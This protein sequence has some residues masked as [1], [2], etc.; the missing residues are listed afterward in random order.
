VLTTDQKGNIAEQAIVFQA[1]KLGIDVYRPVGE[2]GPYDMLRP[3][4]N[5]QR[6]GIN[7]AKDYEFRRY[8]EPTQGAI[9]QLGERRRGTPKVTGSNP[10]GSM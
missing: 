1:I 6:N 7:W 10:V 8:T 5:N 9:A 4:K 2:G 3:T